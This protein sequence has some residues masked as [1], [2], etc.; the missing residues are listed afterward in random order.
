MNMRLVKDAGAE[1]RA[2]TRRDQALLQLQTALRQLFALRHTG[3]LH[4]QITR[5]QGL[6]DGY[7]NC[8][9]DLGLTSDRELLDLVVATRRGVDEPAKAGLDILPGTDV[10]AQAS[11]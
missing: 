4:T 3:A 8:L 6:V 9:L 2:G 11:A 1:E 5:A 10:D 7:M